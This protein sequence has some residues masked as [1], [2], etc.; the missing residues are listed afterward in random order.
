[1]SRLEPLLALQE[2]DLSLDRLRHRRETLPERDAAATAAAAV[3]DLEASIER[4]RVERDEIAREETKFEHEARS[5]AEQ[6]TAA[7]QKLYSGEIASPRELQAL[8]TDVE[9]LKRHQRGIEDRQLVAM[10][11]REPLDARIVVL[12]TELAT[13]T[14]EAARAHDALVAAEAA[15][16]AETGTERAARDELVA[17]IEPDL[18]T[19]Y[20]TARVKANGVGA[21]RLVGNTCQGCH[22]TIPST[23]VERIKKSVDG[24]V[25]HCDNCGTILVP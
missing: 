5:L 8:Q 20:D 1:V 25:G 15:V 2:R 16:D 22:L 17:G 14:D 18:V 7:E 24:E 19:A 11:R 12:G 10:E 6:A 21:A 13:A 3:G 9:Q 4:T 23:E